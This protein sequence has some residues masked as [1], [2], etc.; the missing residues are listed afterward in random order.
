MTRGEKVRQVL[1]EK[2]LGRMIVVIVTTTAAVVAALLLIARVSWNIALPH[3]EAF[4][5]NLVT[6]VV[7][8]TLR[9]TRVTQGEIEDRLSL[10]ERV[11]SLTAR[12]APVSF[13]GHGVVLNENRT[14]Q[15]GDFLRIRYIVQR[16]EACGGTITR[17]FLDTNT[18]QFFTGATYTERLTRAPVTDIFAR[19][20]ASVEVPDKLPPGR[21][22]LAST[23][24]D[25]GCDLPAR[26]AVPYSEPFI[27][28]AREPR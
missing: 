7:E 28:T 6:D 21:Y 14:V 9:D 8:E 2:P 26:S 3:V 4:V 23:L 20:V 17:Q 5:T 22:E 1:V 10:I 24:D 16:H 19:F 27:V 11:V 13:L 15:Q 12:Q 25:E 18:G